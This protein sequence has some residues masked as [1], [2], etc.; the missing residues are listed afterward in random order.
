MFADK[1]L[2]KQ[3]VKFVATKEQEDRIRQVFQQTLLGPKDA[4][5]LK[6]FLF[7]L[8]SFQKISRKKYP[9]LAPFTSFRIFTKKLQLY[10]HFIKWMNCSN[11]FIFQH[12]IKVSIPSTLE[13]NS[14]ENVADL[15]SGVTI[16]QKQG[17]KLEC[18]ANFSKA[19]NT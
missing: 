17:E 14:Q 2:M 11:L 16:K 6:M 19:V 15:G 8:L 4:G 12:T 3:V 7:C 1:N 18:S 13:L 9:V 5:T 10:E